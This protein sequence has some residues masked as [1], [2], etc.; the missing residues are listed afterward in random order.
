MFIF[1]VCATL[2]ERKSK[3]CFNSTPGVFRITKHQE[4]TTYV[5][6]VEQLQDDQKQITLLLFISENSRME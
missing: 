1:N 2:R 4:T 6:S 3:Q 5:S